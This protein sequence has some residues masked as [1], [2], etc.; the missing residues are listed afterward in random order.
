MQRHK[1]IKVI[2][3]I[4][5]HKDKNHIHYNK[6]GKSLQR[7]PACLHD[8]SLREERTEEMHFNIIW[9][10]YDEPIAN[11][12]EKLEAIPLKSETK[13]ST[14]HISSNI[15]FKTLDRAMLKEEN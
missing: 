13:A 9:A 14:Q 5:V 4:S 6:L 8:I 12:R 15:I 7:K 1:T 3:H 10:K 2:N 11:K